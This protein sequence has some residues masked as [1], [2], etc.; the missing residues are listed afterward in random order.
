MSFIAELRRRNVIRMAGLYL[1]GAWLL[2]QV[3]DTLLPVFEA[4]S[5]VM[6]AVTAVLAIGFFV[7]LA[8]S[9]IFEL[10]PEGLK[11]DSEVP[12]QLSIAPQTARRMN[13]AII[14][15]L[16][17]AVTYFALDKFVLAPER[18]A[19]AA[20]PNAAGRVTGNPE[21]PDSAAIEKSIAVLPFVDMSR[22]KDQEYFSDGL[23][24][25][26][27][28]MLSRL[29]DLKVISRTSSFAF[30]GKAMDVRDIGNKLGVAHILEGSVQQSGGTLRITAQ[31]IRTGDGA[32]LW[33]KQ[34]DRKM[35]DI[36]QIQD[37]VA[38]QVVEAIQ[39][40]L[41]AADRQHMLEQ[42]TDNVSAYQEYLKGAALLPGRKIA[43]M[44]KAVSHFERAIQLD[45]NY[46]R[47][48]AMASIAL[49]LLG[50]YTTDTPEMLARR[51]QYLERALELS[52]GLGE[53][54]IAQANR[55]QGIG[56]LEAS[57][58][59]Y[60][61]GIDLAPSYSSG[62]QWY[63]E[64]LFYGLG[65][66]RRGLPMFERALVLDPLSPV[67]R[68]TYGNALANI[69]RVDE[70]FASN[71]K[72]IAEFPDLPIAIRQQAFLYATRGDL[73]QSLRA[74]SRVI[75]LEPSEPNRVER[76]V[77]MFEF[78]AIAE[79]ERCENALG[80]SDQEANDRR[81]L[82]SWLHYANSDFKGALALTKSEDLTD[83]WQRAEYLRLI[84]KSTEALELY[85]KVVP[86]LFESSAQSAAS[87]Y[88][89]DTVS[90]AAAM[91]QAGEVD[92]AQ[93]LLRLG[94]KASAQ[95]P[96]NGALGR[97]WSEVQ[98]YGLLGDFKSAC[99]AL[100]DAAD[101]GFFLTYTTLLIDPAL[102][103]LRKQDCYGEQIAR[104]REL[105]ENQVLSARKAGLLN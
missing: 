13:R 93:R 99:K 100:S 9:W 59:A 37:E 56:D 63:G 15:V 61:R 64:L 78:G 11:R 96:I 60:L 38:T 88:P 73:V 36:F 97:R 28:D 47:A 80:S 86:E 104:I 33:S 31:L 12:A 66:A 5:W 84:G 48:Y 1:V 20:L 24:E 74:R 81:K 8:F 101:Q 67:V 29:P 72:L 3:A 21:S 27:L 23:A 41:P 75:A 45:P 10:T 69:G 105:A 6:K 52:P 54:H 42:S 89:G 18:K 35:A 76:C 94:L 40:A 102:A 79:A 32:H 2:L 90:V 58:K 55:L 30:K 25:T 70:A 26:M 51:D 43:D 44:R 16:L 57:E 53:A 39:G 22:S 19:V 87:S 85:R 34:Y 62:F 92:K 82:K 91:L 7:A 17:L 14:A 50:E 68:L 83:A 46:A 4:P 98:A 71:A 49:G 103:K 77:T 95:L 65:D